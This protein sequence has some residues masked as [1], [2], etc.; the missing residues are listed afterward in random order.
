MVNE[1]GATHLDLNTSHP[2]SIRDVAT[3][4]RSEIGNIVSNHLL[5]EKPWPGEG[6]M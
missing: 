4:F 1:D 5:E 3:F 6:W 2:L